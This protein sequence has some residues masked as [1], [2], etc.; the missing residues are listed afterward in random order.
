MLFMETSVCIFSHLY[1]FMIYKWYLSL[2]GPHDKP[3]WD[4]TRKR[5]RGSK[6]HFPKPFP[7][8]RKYE[9]IYPPEVD[10]FVYITDDT[11]TKRQLLR[12]EHLLLKV[13]AF[14]LTVP[15]T[16]QFLLQYLRRQGVCI[17]TENLAKVGHVTPRN[18][19]A[20]W[21]KQVA[22]FSSSFLFSSLPRAQKS[23]LA[24]GRELIWRKWLL[25][26]WR[27]DETF[28]LIMFG[29][30]GLSNHPQVLEKKK[31]KLGNYSLVAYRPQASS[32]S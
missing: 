5:V 20:N 13:L 27:N 8:C 16:N 11:Y 23:F 14:D 4:S 3:G 19:S 12:M 28:P 31:C 21:I 6:L 29:R 7:F 2:Q 24:I 15:T 10:E 32:T 9:E 18:L 30:C 25:H 1:H 22:S 26:V 17:R